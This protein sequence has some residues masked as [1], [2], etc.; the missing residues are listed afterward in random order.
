MP[1]MPLVSSGKI[2]R[3]SYGDKSF[4]WVSPPLGLA[5]DDR[6]NSIGEERS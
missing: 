5:M 1:A 3:G 6:G 2:M 4:W